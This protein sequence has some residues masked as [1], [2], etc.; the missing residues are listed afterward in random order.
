MTQ[1]DEF[2]TKLGAYNINSLVLSKKNINSLF[3]WNQDGIN[4]NF[5]ALTNNLKYECLFEMQ[6]ET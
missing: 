2:F 5:E 6:V 3:I 4:G 1:W